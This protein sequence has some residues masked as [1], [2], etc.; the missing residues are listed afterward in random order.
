MVQE[1]ERDAQPGDGMEDGSPSRD[2][3]IHGPANTDLDVDAH[4]HAKEAV[5]RAQRLA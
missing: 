4:R 3:R 5:I 2:R 1:D